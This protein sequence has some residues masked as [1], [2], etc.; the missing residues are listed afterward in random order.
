MSSFS[1]PPNIFL[2][3]SSNSEKQVELAKKILEKTR[4]NKIRWIR[5]ATGYLAVVPPIRIVFQSSASTWQ[6]FVVYVGLKEVV[7]TQNSLV[8]G[9]ISQLTGLVSDPLLATATE[10]Y[11]LISVTDPTDVEGAINT[12]DKL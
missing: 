2:Q 5:V 4:Q 9:I 12:L 1:Q 3:Q 6:L 7:K 10:L 8:P 11:N